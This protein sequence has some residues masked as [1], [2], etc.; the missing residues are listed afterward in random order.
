MKNSC[1][2]LLDYFLFTVCPP[3]KNVTRPYTIFLFIKG[4]KV[5]KKFGLR[6]GV[7]KAFKLS[8]HTHRIQYVVMSWIK[9]FT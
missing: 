4:Q 3:T 8:S 7:L 2:S 5:L 6:T 1:L 9:R